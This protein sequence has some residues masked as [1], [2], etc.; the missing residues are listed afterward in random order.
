MRLI[1]FKKPDRPMTLWSG[2]FARLS[3]VITHYDLRIQ[4][5]EGKNNIR[6]RWYPARLRY[7]WVHS[8][9]EWG[10]QMLEIELVC[11]WYISAIWLWCWKLCEKMK[12]RKKEKN[13]NRLAT[14]RILENDQ[15]PRSMSLCGCGWL[16]ESSGARKR[17]WRKI[18]GVWI[19]L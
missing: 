12:N 2:A 14:N 1:T 9:C 11:W 5:R 19:A 3:L 6:S 18:N 13:R 4:V 16:A 10:L 15:I 8:A 17:V 7:I